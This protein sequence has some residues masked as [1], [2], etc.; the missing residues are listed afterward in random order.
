[1]RNPT[2]KIARAV[3]LKPLIADAGKSAESSTV[4]P[5]S[6]A[7]GAI[8]ST[9]GRPLSFPIASDDGNNRHRSSDDD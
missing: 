8:V 3:G 4:A 1:M 2:E 9:S 6:R 7:S 5:V